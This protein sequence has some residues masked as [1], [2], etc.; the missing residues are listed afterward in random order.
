MC[1]RFTLSTSRAKIAARFKLS[2]AMPGPSLYPPAPRYN[3]APTQAVDVIRVADGA[4]FLSLL[5]WG[6]VPICQP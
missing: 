2:D 3:I 6:L 5:H 1:G 4:R